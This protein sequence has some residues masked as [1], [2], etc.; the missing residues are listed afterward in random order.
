MVLQIFLTLALALS[1]LTTA[2]P[3]AEPGDDLE[4]TRCLGPP[5]LPNYNFAEGT[6]LPS[7]WSFGISAGPPGPTHQ[8][9]VPYPVTFVEQIH[10]GCG[11]HGGPCLQV[12]WGSYPGTPAGALDWSQEGIEPSGP[13]FV[14]QQ[15]KKYELSVAYKLEKRSRNDANLTCWAS[16]QGT[17]FPP[18]PNQWVFVVQLDD[19]EVGRYHRRA[20]EF[21]GFEAGSQVNTVGC[22][23][24]FGPGGFGSVLD[25]GHIDVRE[26]EC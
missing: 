8:P 4:P 5:L 1:G 23:L 6:P 25:L 7:N 15:G 16:T 22:T 24:L 26:K 17:V 21:D 13:G 11:K 10:A 3:A 12:N 14:G 19:A 20:G 18:Y 9:H 2:L